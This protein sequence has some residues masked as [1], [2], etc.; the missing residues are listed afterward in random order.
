MHVGKQKIYDQPL[1]VGNLQQ[2]TGLSNVGDTRR[3]ERFMQ[4]LLKGARL[5]ERHLC[6]LSMQAACSQLAY[7]QGNLSQW[8]PLVAASPTGWAL[9]TQR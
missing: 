2:A 6:M 3:L 5:I 8:Q 4:K 1:M 9:R 7:L